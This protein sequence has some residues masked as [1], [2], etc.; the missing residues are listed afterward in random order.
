MTKEHPSAVPWVPGR[1]GPPLPRQSGAG[2]LTPEREHS[3]SAVP[4]E[5]SSALATHDSP[6]TTETDG[7]DDSAPRACCAEPTGTSR[8]AKS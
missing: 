5:E 2:P 8:P 7:G 6:T 1:G 4:G 3:S